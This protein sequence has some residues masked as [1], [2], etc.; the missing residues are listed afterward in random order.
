VRDLILGWLGK[1]TLSVQQEN[2]LLAARLRLVGDGH[3]TQELQQLAG[4]LHLS[5]VTEFVGRVPHPQVF[6]ELSKLDIY[7]ALSR[8]DSESFGVAIIK[9]GAAGRPVV[10]SDAGGLP[11][12]VIDQKTG[13]VVPRENPQAAADALNQ[14]VMN[15]EQRIQMGEAGKEHVRANYDWSICVHQMLCVY[16]QTIEQYQYPKGLL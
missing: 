4:E 16:R 2:S 6:E 5:K 3:Q 7:V 15:S 14:L 9:A 1:I 8:L 10:V 12:V 13:L 11:E